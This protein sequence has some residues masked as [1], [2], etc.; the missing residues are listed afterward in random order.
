M[1]DLNELQKWTTAINTLIQILTD[2]NF[3]T[4]YHEYTKKDLIDLA[5]DH[6]NLSSMTEAPKKQLRSKFSYLYLENK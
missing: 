6:G 3:E 2:P 4:K 1:N 5:F